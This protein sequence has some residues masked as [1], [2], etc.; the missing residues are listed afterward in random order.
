[1]PGLMVKHEQSTDVIRL[2]SLRARFGLA[3]STIVA[4]CTA[5]AEKA[6]H[7]QTEKLRDGEVLT[8]I[9]C[10]QGSWNHLLRSEDDKEGECLKRKES[11]LQIV[12][13]P[14]LTLIM[15]SDHMAYL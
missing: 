9:G 8:Q 6:N 1:M 11:Q 2:P 7:E 13:G 10:R 14:R 15:Y 3:S 4:N 12:D 5:S